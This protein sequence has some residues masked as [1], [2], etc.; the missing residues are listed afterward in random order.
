MPTLPVAQYSTEQCT[1]QS[2]L[3]MPRQLED[4]VFPLG[5][6][7][8]VSS[9]LWSECTAARRR[10]DSVSDSAASALPVVVT[11]TTHGHL[12]LTLGHSPINR[13]FS[14]LEQMSLE[15][16]A[17][18]RVSAIARSH[19]PILFFSS[20]SILGLGSSLFLFGGGC[21]VGAVVMVRTGTPAGGD[22]CRP[23]ATAS[24]LC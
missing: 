22:G 10:S 18:V 6:A 13:M 11:T 19:P 2:T 16:K 4:H 14:Q 15:Q 21:W 8:E 24:R 17:K 5:S 23:R 3:P 12:C 7:S 9:A 1:E 20:C